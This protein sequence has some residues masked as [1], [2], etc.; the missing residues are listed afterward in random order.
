VAVKWYLPEELHEE[1]IRL[2]RRAQTGDVELLAPGTLRPEFFNALWQQHRRNNLP[3]QEVRSA[4]EQFALDPVAL[5]V[6]EDLMPRAVEITFE[7]GV[8]VY[9]ALFLALAEDADTLVVT[10]DG[11]LLKALEGTTHARLAYPLADLDSLVPD[12]R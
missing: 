11:K 7:T 10:A 4:W 8:I 1:A 5:Y 12:V 6:P 9:D 3:L 2:A